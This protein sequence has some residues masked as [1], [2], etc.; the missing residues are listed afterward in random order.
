M[1]EFFTWIVC[2]FVCLFV[3]RSICLA[4]FGQLLRYADK[5]I[6]NKPVRHSSARNASRDLQP[7]ATVAAT[8]QVIEN[9]GIGLQY[10]S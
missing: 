9:G 2:L 6:V 8:K 5:R 7:L 4:H 3:C 1:I 10:R